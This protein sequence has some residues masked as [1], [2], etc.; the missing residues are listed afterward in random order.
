MDLDWLKDFL[1]L[2]EQKSFSRAAEVR[3]VTQPAF[4]RRIRALEDWIGVPLF[5]RSA[6]GATLTPAGAYFQPLAQDLLRNLQH[7]QRETRAV[8]E[9]EKGALSIAATHALS[10]TFFPSWIRRHMRFE[11]L[12]TLNLI[13]DSLEACEQIMLGGEVHFLLCHHHAQVPTRFEAERFQ[14]IRVGDDV[15]VPFCAPDAE[16]RP[17]WLLPGTIERPA[18]LLAYSQ[19]S[20][21]GRILSAQT[22]L[23]RD[24]NGMAT[25]F[26]SHLAATLLT[27]ARDG[28]GIAW[29]PLTLAEEDLARAR[30]VR[31]G[32][33]R[34]DIPIEIR[35]FRS[36]D[37]R[38]AAADDLW[39]SLQAE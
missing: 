8:G 27:M 36:P 37:C 34:F 13:S 38:N 11:A 2:A 18:R 22:A 9:R 33:E 4:S 5:L 12:G 39:A 21:L 28:H 7:L 31:A 20:G 29:L 24:T 23:A 15:L 1:A 16:G 26:T 25:V 6:Q 17:H 19:A 14:S 3:N 30:L 32:P 10:F 35:L